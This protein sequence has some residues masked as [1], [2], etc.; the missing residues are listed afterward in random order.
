MRFNHG[1][2][3]DGESRSGDNIEARRP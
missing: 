2:G 3:T 1:L